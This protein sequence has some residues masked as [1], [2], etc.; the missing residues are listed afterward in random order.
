VLIQHCDQQTTR[1]ICDRLELAPR[2]RKV[3][4]KDRFTA[5]SIRNR[6]ERNLPK[7]DSSLHKQLAALSIEMILY[8]MVCARSLQVKRAISH[9]VTKLRHVTISVT[10]KD[11]MERGLKP[12]P[13]YRDIM[14]AVLNTKLN[15]LVQTRE[16]ELA[17]VENYL[18][19]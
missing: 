16:D 17:F 11:L 10:G 2:Y 13:V 1:E 8:M 15:G 5:E 12:G 7:D 14:Q 9:Y 6:M 19:K 3:L 18:S 4:L